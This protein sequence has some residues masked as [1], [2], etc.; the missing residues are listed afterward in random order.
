MNVRTEE[1][2]RGYEQ[3]DKQ[4]E[5]IQNAELSISES[6]RSVLPRTPRQLRRS[7]RF[8]VESAVSLP[9]KGIAHIKKGS[10]AV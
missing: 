2:A 7:R 5:D 8:A 10:L 9:S 1:M 6:D 3:K 4:P